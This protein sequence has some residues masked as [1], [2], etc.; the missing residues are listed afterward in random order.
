MNT[1][2]DPTIFS[3]T[4]TE[5]SI[6]YNSKNKEK[7]EKH[8]KPTNKKQIKLSGPSKDTQPL[9]RRKTYMFY[10]ERCLR[11]GIK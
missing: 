9:E 7:I 3:L 8:V 11:Y 2:F 4:K 5:G 10:V 1:L 6:A